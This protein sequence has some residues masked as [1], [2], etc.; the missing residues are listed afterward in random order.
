MQYIIK[1]GILLIGLFFLYS[2]GIAENLEPYLQE[3]EEI[4]FTSTLAAPLRHKAAQLGTPVKIFQYVR[5]NYDYAPYHGSRSNA[6]NTFFARRG[7]DV[8]LASLLI[9]MFRSQN[10]PARYAVGRD[11]RKMEDV[12]NWLGVVDWTVA[13]GLIK[14]QGI[15]KD[16]TYSHTSFESQRLWVFDLEHA[17]VEVFVPASDAGA[18]TSKIDCTQQP[19]SCA[20]FSIDPAFKRKQYSQPFEDLI[21]VYDQVQ[22]DYERLYLAEKNQDESIL[23][24]NPLRI[25]EEQ[26]LD[27]LE[28]HHPGKTLDDVLYQGTIIPEVRSTLQSTFPYIPLEQPRQYASIAEHDASESTPWAKYLTIHV[29]KRGPE[30]K[31]DPASPIFVNQKFLLST[32]T[33]QALAYTFESCGRACIQAKTLLDG[34]EWD[35]FVSS[36]GSLLWGNPFVIDLEIDFYAGRTGKV[37]YPDNVVGGYYLVSYGGYHSNWTQVEYASDKLIAAQAQYPVAEDPDK[38]FAPFIDSNLNGIK[39][40][41]ELLV[42]ENQDAMDLL[43][44]ALLETAEKLYFNQF[45]DANERLSALTHIKKPILSWLGVISSVHRV[46]YVDGV[47]ASFQPGGMLIDMKGI[48]S[49]IGWHL[50]KWG[51]K[52]DRHERLAGHIASAYEHEVWEELTEYEAI[53]SISGIQKALAGG[54]VL[55][56]PKK[57][58]AEDTVAE[59]YHALGFSNQAPEPFVMKEKEIFGTQQ[60]VWDLP[61]NNS[62]A[63]FDTFQATINANTPEL[64]KMQRT[65]SN[66]FNQQFSEFERIRNFIRQQLD[67]VPNCRFSESGGVRWEGKTHSGECTKVLREW[68][69]YYHVQRQLNP[70]SYQYFDKNQGFDPNAQVYRK[71]RAEEGQHA[72]GVIKKMRDDLYLPASRFAAAEYYIPSTQTMDINSNVSVYI[73]NAYYPNGQLGLST[74]ALANRTFRA[75]GGHITPASTVNTVTS[76]IFEPPE[77]GHR[78]QFSIKDD[79]I[80]VTLE[81]GWNQIIPRTDS[82][83]VLSPEEYF[84]LFLEESYQ[85][86]TMVA[87]QQKDPHANRLFNQWE[88]QSISPHMSTAQFQELKETAYRELQQI[89]LYKPLWIFLD[90]P[91]GPETIWLPLPHVVPPVDQ[92]P[93]ERAAQLSVVVDMTADDQ[94]QIV[95]HKGWNLIEKAIG[96]PIERE[97]LSFVHPSN[98]NISFNSNYGMTFWQYDAGQWNVSPQHESTTQHYGSLSKIKPHEDLWVYTTRP[99]ILTIRQPEVPSHTI[100]REPAKSLGIVSSPS[101]PVGLGSAEHHVNPD[102]SFSYA[103]PIK[104]VLGTH[105]I[106]PNLAMVYNSNAGNGMLGLGWHLSGISSITRM[107]YGQGI[108]YD[109]NDTFVGPDGRLVDVSGGN[110]LEYHDEYENWNRYVPDG[111]NCGRGPCSWTLYRS[112]GAKLHFGK[113]T[114]D[115]GSRVIT[116]EPEKNG[117]VRVWALDKF[118]DIHGNYYTIEYIQHNGAFYPKYIRYTFNAKTGLA[119]NR[120]IEFQYDKTGRTDYMNSYAHNTRVQIRWRL[121]RITVQSNGETVREYELKY[122]TKNSVFSN[123]SLLHSVQ[124]TNGDESLPAH[125]FTWT[126]GGFLSS[127]SPPLIFNLGEEKSELYTS[128]APVWIITGDFDGNGTKD[129]L[130]IKNG[131]GVETT[132]QNHVFFFDKATHQFVQQSSYS[133]DALLQTEP[134]DSKGHVRVYSGDFNGDGRTDILRTG[135]LVEN[136]AEEKTG[137]DQIWLSTREGT[138]VLSE[139]APDLTHAG[140]YLQQEIHLGDFNDDGRTDILR[141]KLDAAGAQH[142]WHGGTDYS[143]PIPVLQHELLAQSSP[144]SFPRLRSRIYVG[145]F[146]GDRKAD[147]LRST[148][149]TNENKLWISNGSGFTE[150]AAAGLPA[151]AFH[152][153]DNRTRLHLGDINGDGKTDLLQTHNRDNR[154]AKLYFANGHGFEMPIDITTAKGPLDHYKHQQYQQFLYLQDV[155]GD[156]KTD[157]V[158][159]SDAGNG[160]HDTIFS[161][162]DGKFIEK[163]MLVPKGAFHHKMGKKQ[164]HLADFDG[165]GTVDILVAKDYKDLYRYSTYMNDEGVDDQTADDSEPPSDITIQST[166]WQNQSHPETMAQITNDQG[167]RIAVKMK[168]ALQMPGAVLP[169]RTSCQNSMESQGVETKAGYGEICGLPL[170]SPRYLVNRITLNNNAPVGTDYTKTYTTDYQYENGRYTP[171]KI[172]D[173]RNLGFEKITIREQW[174]NFKTETIYNQNKPFQG[175]VHHISQYAHGLLFSKTEKTYKLH[176][177]VPLSKQIHLILPYHEIQSTY[178]KGQFVFHMDLLQTHPDKYGYPQLVRKAISEKNQRAISTLTTYMHKDSLA[179]QTIPSWNG[180]IS[181]WRLGMPLQTKKMKSNLLIFQWEQESMFRQ[182]LETNNLEDLLQWEKFEYHDASKGYQL[183]GHQQYLFCYVLNDCTTTEWIPVP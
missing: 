7:N 136:E 161:W 142:L 60:I 181:E 19:D 92:P 21:K 147:I 140:N 166:I 160:Y 51:G 121:D 105:G 89:L 167:G 179:D 17:W 96:E 145:D 71:G 36:N 168:S 43:K 176:E 15:D 132:N 69:N 53:S 40:N 174:K 165:N 57:S 50:D 171:G 153:A 56:N 52:T 5:N 98:P 131:G 42:V 95:L 79:I 58:A 169:A 91:Q 135:Y 26:I 129:I 110:R 138:F 151:D 113:T 180:N 75:S 38:P 178:E 48:H 45:R 127:D 33:T 37:Q 31:A 80:G 32:L 112:D 102:G 81:Q 155:D 49:G 144:F 103:I 97:D 84:E 66:W 123:Q 82:S 157:I 34:Q 141:V 13:Y 9:A 172:P 150:M 35:T 64:R 39:D 47:A 78:A 175:T 154:W 54:A 28:E 70:Q 99:V 24:K 152:A 128:D 16:V 59:V 90:D 3:T 67:N 156:K 18:G 6:I 170:S 74:Y 65:Y 108:Q 20:W 88:V 162:S 11:R 22:F 124:E 23:G 143:T 111:T 27:Y 173:R 117:A 4:P 120:T 76:R 177:T 106:A 137:A 44:G 164:I 86:I 94:L 30:G 148:V 63:T 126:D 119:A 73:H 68:E 2:T 183:K 125:T 41:G 77:A 149:G 93:V 29:H 104:L 182:Q 134:G 1:L 109:E 114:G 61:A 25:Y 146:N 158:S 163:N 87:M 107:N 55:L 10:I 116:Q 12:A 100:S 159:V 122:R 14:Y 133:F 139:H 46:E 130:R 101:D 8:D 62:T 83:M 118:E 115:N 72:T 85:P